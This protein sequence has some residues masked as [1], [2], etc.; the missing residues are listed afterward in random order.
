MI[1]NEVADGVG[2]DGSRRGVR[3]AGAEFES[4]SFGFG[5]G[6]GGALGDEV[7]GEADCGGGGGHCE[8]RG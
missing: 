1:R 5:G 8:A 6:A 3:E 7:A 2:G 4:G